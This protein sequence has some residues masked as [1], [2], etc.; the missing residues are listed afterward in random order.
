MNHVVQIKADGSTSPLGGSVLLSAVLESLILNGKVTFFQSPSDKCIDLW[1]QS[2][3][4]YKT[5]KS[6]QS[7]FAEGVRL[8]DDDGIIHIYQFERNQ[9]TQVYFKING[10]ISFELLVSIVKELL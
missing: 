2:H 4:G 9:I 10:R 1:N 6:R 7:Y 3:S 5:S 8:V